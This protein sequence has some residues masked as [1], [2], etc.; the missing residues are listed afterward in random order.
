MRTPRALAATL[1]RV[2][3]IVS[4]LG[5]WCA[6]QESSGL[7]LYLKAVKQPDPYRQIASL[8]SFL[9]SNSESALRR[10][11]LAL[12]AWD[13]ARTEDRAHAVD[14]ARQ[15]W[16]IDPHDPIAIAV[17]A[18][19]DAL[20]DPTPIARSRTL[21]AALSTNPRRPEGLR[22]IDFAMMKQFIWRS[23]TGAAGLAYVD[24]KDYSTAVSFLQP[25]VASAPGDPRYVF[26][27]ANALHR[28]KGHD[29]E[30]FWYYARAVDL[31]AYSPQGQQIAAY[32][33]D[34]YHHAGGKDQDWQA[35]L[36][37]ARAPRETL[38]PVVEARR[39]GPPVATS[40]EA[41]ARHKRGNKKADRDA[42]EAALFK[43]RS[44]ITHPSDAPSTKPPMSNPVSLGILI[45]TSRLT[46]DYRRSVVFA[47]SDLVKHLRTQDEAFILAFSD[48]LDFVQDLTDNDLLLQDA[49][50]HLKPAKGE[51]LFDAVSFAAGHLKR[52]ARN[53]NRIL[54]VISDGKAGRGQTNS[55]DISAGLAQVRV[56][57]IGIGVT[58]PAQRA[59]LTNLSHYSGGE[60]T[61]IENPAEFRS[62]TRELAV[63]MGIQV[64]R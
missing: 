33:H 4:L 2:F 7:E 57:C 46:A 29:A 18:D 31:S 27:L 56:D 35:F 30:A 55:F 10:D 51:A 43:D 11:A 45:Q 23:L 41:S 38:A 3:V 1:L 22:E 34:Q 9:S 42:A 58:D 8:E 32:A 17:F 21:Q 28:I 16:L 13:Y 12:V 5:A 37:A 24:L 63:Q 26:G 59:L 39:S 14:R 36:E 15:L 6:A 25:V 62:S 53:P 47:L 44:G 48:Q 60:T 40:T 20:T 50:D 64:P 52:I 61:F 49:L 19:N 54:L